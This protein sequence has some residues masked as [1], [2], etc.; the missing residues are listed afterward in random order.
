MSPGT[1]VSDKII[2]LWYL[3][4]QEEEFRNRSSPYRLFCKTR[5]M[6]EDMLQQN[7]DSK[8]LFTKFS[9]NLKTCMANDTE[10]TSLKTIDMIFFPIKQAN[11]YYV[12]VYNLKTPSL[13]ILDNSVS[14]MVIEDKY[15]ELP[16]NA[17]ISN[18]TL[19]EKC[20]PSK[21]Q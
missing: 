18:A 15:G 7:K 11:H 12:I 10:I 21:G 5:T 19:S 1:H 8:V 2:D 3:L 6:T 9:D 14:N 13:V 17:A 4:N 16:N 20:T